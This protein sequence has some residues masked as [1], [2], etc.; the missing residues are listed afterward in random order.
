MPHDGDRALTRPA[1]PAD[2]ECRE[3][4]H[5]FE[6]RLAVLESRDEPQPRP[7]APIPVTLIVFDVLH[8]GAFSWR[9]VRWSRGVAH[10]GLTLRRQLRTYQSYSVIRAASFSG[11]STRMFVPS[12]STL[13]IHRRCKLR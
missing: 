12:R 8:A 6:E 9:G 3:V 4:A 1:E 13:T 11:T 10:D 7:V 2:R 5:R